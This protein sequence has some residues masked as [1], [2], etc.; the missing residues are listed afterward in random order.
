[1]LPTVTIDQIRNFDPPPCYD[2]GRYLPE[3]WTGTALDV[4]A[5]EEC[6][7]EDRLWVVL[8]EEFIDAR[9]C[10]RSSSTHEPCGCLP[11]GVH[12]RRWRSW[13]IPTRAALRPATWPNAM[14]MGK[15]RIANWL[16]RGLPRGQPQKLPYGLATESLLLMWQCLP[17]GL[18][19]QSLP[20]GTSQTLPRGMPHGPR[21]MIT[22]WIARGTTWQP[23]GN[24]RWMPRGLCSSITCARCSANTTHHPPCCSTVG[25]VSFLTSPL[26]WCI[27]AV[28][29]GE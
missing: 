14:P 28:K 12:G 29:G 24:P 7:A 10:M 16:P 26:C 17:C 21:N 22:H 5:V 8:H 9:S 6:P 13:I 15:R 1:M 3:G 25:R 2:P 4:L 11:C 23:R 20:R 19:R 18:P 27:M